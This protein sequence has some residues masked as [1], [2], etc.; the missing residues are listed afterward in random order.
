MQKKRILALTVSMCMLLGLLLTGPALASFPDVPA[1]MEEAVEFLHQTRIM[2]GWEGKFHPDEGFTREMLATVVVRMLNADDEAVALGDQAATMYADSPP[3]GHW[4]NG[5]LIVAFNLELMRGWTDLENQRVFD[6]SGVVSFDETIAIVLRALGY[7]PLTGPDWRELNRDLALDVGLIT[8][9]IAEKGEDPA[10]RGDIAGIVFSGMVDVPHAST[11]QYLSEAF[12]LDED[13]DDEADTSLESLSIS[14]EVSPD[15]VP[16]GGGQ[17]VTINVNVVDHLGHPV[18]DVR[19]NFFAEAFEAGGRD[20]RLS[21][22]TAYTNPFGHASVV[23]TTLGEDDFR[24]VYINVDASK[25]DFMEFG[26]IQFVAANQVAT[27]S[28]VVQDPFT[29]LPLANTPVHF[30]PRDLDLNSIGFVETSDEGF[31]SAV[32]PLGEYGVTVPD[33]DPRDEVTA[34]VSTAGGHYTVDF[35]KGILKGVIKGLPPGEMVMAIGPGFNQNDKSNW[36]LVDHLDTDGSFYMALFPNTYEL[37]AGPHGLVVA[38]GISIQTGQVT[39][40]GT[41]HVD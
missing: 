17:A 4:S 28:G 15:V 12:D 30:G 9:D 21:S 14:L 23:Y 7:D 3:A 24:F 36:T 41:L 32:V 18:E 31:Y 10:S 33:A 22:S 13:E 38:T 39:D 2:R 20:H 29:G 35:N 8:P 6:P 19:V 25:D 40:L 16:A 1:G 34:H 11:G 5:Y 37:Y 26:Q 27:V